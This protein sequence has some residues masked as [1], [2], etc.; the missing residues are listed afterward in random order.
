MRAI[1]NRIDD[2]G[3]FES[4]GDTLH[5]QLITVLIDG[6]GDIDRDDERG[7]DVVRSVRAAKPGRT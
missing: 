5:L 6:T 3:V 1:D 7:V 2:V 4:L